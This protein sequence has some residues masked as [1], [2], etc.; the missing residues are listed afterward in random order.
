MEPNTDERLA[1]ADLERYAWNGKFW[2]LSAF[3]G[4]VITSEAPASRNLVQVPIRG[5]FEDLPGLIALESLDNKA[6]VVTLARALWA[7]RS[8]DTW[9]MKSIPEIEPAMVGF[10]AEEGKDPGKVVAG[11]R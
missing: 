3:R 8:D 10:E 2:T 9:L 4:H 5:S 7:R 1:T 6:T 11:L